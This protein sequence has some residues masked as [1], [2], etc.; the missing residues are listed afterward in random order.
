MPALL[1]EEWTGAFRSAARRR[2]ITDVRILR[3][4]ACTVDIISGL[5]RRADGTT[6]RLASRELE[7]LAFLARREG[8]AVS[9]HE[10]HERVWR[11]G[12]E[13]V[14]RA[15]DVAIR[16][17]RKKLEADPAKP[18]HL[19]TQHGAGYLFVGPAPVATAPPPPEDEPMVGR[20]EEIEALTRRLGEASGVVFL[21]GPPGAGKTR[22]ARH[23]AWRLSAE[24]S[25]G[26][27]FCDLTEATDRDD[28]VRAVARTLGMALAGRTRL[29]TASG[30]GWSRARARATRERDMLVVRQSTP[31]SC[32]VRQ[33]STV[34][35]RAEP[36]STPLTRSTAATPRPAPT[37]DTLANPSGARAIVA[38][39]LRAR[40]TQP[41]AIVEREPTHPGVRDLAPGSTGCSG[42]P[43]PS[44]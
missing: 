31:V 28:V 14:S 10:L 24:L 29:A 22:L 4:T 41:D 19:L 3:L 42:S 8:Q 35:T 30:Q 23:L 32:N 9:R 12:P 2:S 6:D 37:A 34:G 7:L 33:G 1:T 21:V 26:A 38:P 44:R 5:I 36:W 20:T 43:P 15:A 27:W 39:H 13:V 18:D 17:L 25:G 16:R 11:H 40:S